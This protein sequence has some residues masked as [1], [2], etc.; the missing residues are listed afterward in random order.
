MGYIHFSAITIAAAHIWTEAQRSPRCRGQADVRQRLKVLYQRCL[1]SLQPLLADIGARQISNVLRSSATLRFSPDDAVPGMVHALTS[2]FVQFIDAVEEKQRPNAQHVANV[3]W[4]FATMS[5][6]AA[7]LQVVAALC[8]H[9]EGLTLHQDAQQRPKA[10]ECSNVLWALGTLKQTPPHNR[11]LDCLCDYML[12][13]IGSRNQRPHPNAQAIANVLWA[14]AQLKHAPSHVVVA[15][16]FGYLVAL[17]HTPGLQPNSQSISNSFIAS[18]ELGFCVKPTCVEALLKHFLEL[19]MSDVRY[20]EYCNAAWSLAVVQ[21]LDLSTF[22]ALLDKLTAKHKLL[23]K[24]GPQRT[25]A[26]ITTS[27]HRQLYQALAWLMPPPGSKH[28]EAWSSLWS[29]LLT[30]APEPAVRSASSPGLTVMWAAV[31]VQELPYQAQV[32]RGVYWADALLSA[33]D[34][35]NVEVMLVVEGPGDHLTNLPNR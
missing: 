12:T 14:L 34:R 4:A 13:L 23:E 22:G 26:Q 35:G 11:L 3:L 33:H 15:A 9:F 19:Y 18:A 24:S 28:M 27:H 30:V 6:P 17:C 20:Q 8:S 25:T 5:H 32:Q 16:M 7:T 21:C 1:Q 29:R 2:R 10:Q 31:A